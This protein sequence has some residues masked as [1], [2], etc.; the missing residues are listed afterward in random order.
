[1]KRARDVL[2]VTPPRIVKT[3]CG[4]DF[5]RL[6]DDGL[7]TAQV[8]GLNDGKPPMGYPTLT[9]YWK[10]QFPYFTREQAAFQQYRWLDV[11]EI[12]E[13]V[14][15]QIYTADVSFENGNY[16]VYN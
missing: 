16:H 10:K 1:M 14:G 5:V 13:V 3:E 8:Q 4:L 15:L 12:P 6:F 2:K 11:V 7:I 9:A